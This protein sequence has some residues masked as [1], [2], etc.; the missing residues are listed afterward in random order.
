MHISLIFCIFAYT[1]NH[2]MEDREREYLKENIHRLDRWENTPAAPS[3][4]SSDLT[5]VEKEK[6]IDLLYASNERLMSELA[7]LRQDM[8]RQS[9]EM[10]LVD[11][12]SSRLEQ[13]AL[14]AERRAD[15]E[16]AERMMLQSK[17][18]ELLSLVKELRNG[19]ELRA[20]TARAE[21]A[22]KAVADLLASGRTL[23]GQVYGTKSQRRRNDDDKNDDA[24]RDAQS[25]KD[26]MGGRDTVEALPESVKS[27]DGPDTD[28]WVEDNYRS[29]RAYREGA[30]HRTMKAARRCVHESDRDAVPEGWTIVREEKRFA[31]DKTTVIVE[32]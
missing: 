1:G 21:K 5:E 28:I 23:R 15:R 32:H 25:E 17:I 2:F 27:G 6:L 3:G 22:E 4:R 20:M 10:R 19:D 14:A 7:G 18:D 31:Y 13:R 12:R 8:E 24:P 30:R 16:A 26:T 9:G 29:K 11:E